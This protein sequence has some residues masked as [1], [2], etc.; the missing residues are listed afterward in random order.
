MKVW[1][2]HFIKQLVYHVNEGVLSQA[3]YEKI[4]PSHFIKHFLHTHFIKQMKKLFEDLFHP[5][6]KILYI[7][8]INQ[9]RVLDSYL[10]DQQWQKTFSFL[11]SI[12][13]LLAIV[14]GGKKPKQKQNYIH[15]LPWERNEKPTCCISLSIWQAH[16]GCTCHASEWGPKPSSS[17]L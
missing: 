16:A 6:M 7:L 3:P 11:L 17:K 4:L 2:K 9:N 12:F 8:W 1:A 5:F 14:G 13:F 15:G 10:L